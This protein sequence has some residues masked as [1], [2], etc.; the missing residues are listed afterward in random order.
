MVTNPNIS[1]SREVHGYRIDLFSDVAQLETGKP[2]PNHLEWT[3]TYTVHVYRGDYL[4]AGIWVTDPTQ[5]SEYARKAEDYIRK[6]HAA[7]A[8]GQW[9]AKSPVAL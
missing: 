3:V 5:A 4:F 6:E 2:V 1:I 9:F 7:G 8:N